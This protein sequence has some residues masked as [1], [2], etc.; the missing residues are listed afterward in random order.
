MA[1]IS[2]M[3]L[4][5]L[6]LFVSG[7]GSAENNGGLVDPMRPVR[8]QAPA[9]STIVTGPGQA[10]VKS[11][12]LS[13][14]LISAER[15]VAVINGTSLQEGQVLDGYRLLQIEPGR[16]VLKNGQRKIVLH[17]AGT[18]LKKIS[19]NQDVGKGSKQ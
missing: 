10:D 19:V 3:V 2:G 13:A 11:W 15:S 1:K 4:A 18:G 16:V 7:A 17:R 6:L 14:V 9:A 12:Q 8:Y 5:I